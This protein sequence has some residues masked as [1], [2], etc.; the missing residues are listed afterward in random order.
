MTA[1]W[2]RLGADGLGWAATATGAV[3]LAL[4]FSTSSARPLVLAASGASYLMVGALIGLVV[5]GA[6]RHVIGV[7]AAAA[8]AAPAIWTQ[9]PLHVATTASG[10]GPDITV[11]HANILFDGGADPDVVVARVRER[12]V[13]LLTVN[14]LTSAGVEGLTRA[15]LDD[16][17]PHRYLVPGQLASGTGIWSRFPLSDTV[18]HDGFMFHQ[19]SA[20]ADVPGAGQVAVHAFHPVP[21][22]FDTQ[23][24]AAE[25]SRLQDILDR[26]PADVPAVVGGDFNATQGHSQFRA[27]LSGRFAD[28]AEQVGAGTVRTYPTDKSGPPLVAIDHVLVADATATSFESVELPG[29]DHLAVVARIR[30]SPRA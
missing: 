5:F 13:D 30:L 14:E 18:E 21:P 23:D 10:T 26:S 11:M 27:L 24:W 15:G 9:A 1:K 16:M 19:L 2:L 12:D 17:L 22:V 6:R 3:G 8:V 7:L 25:L 29:A 4:H 20:V 28:A